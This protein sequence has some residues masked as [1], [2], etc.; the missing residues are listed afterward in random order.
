M[1]RRLVQSRRVSKRTPLIANDRAPDVPPPAGFVTVTF[2]VPAVAISAAGIVA[3]ICVL[4]TDDGVSAGFVPKFTTAP[5]IKPVPV[6]VNVNAAPPRRG[7]RPGR[8][9]LKCRCGNRINRKGLSCR[10]SP[11]RRWIRDSYSRRARCGYIRRRNRRGQL[12]GT[13]E[14]RRLG[15]AIEL[16][17]RPVD[18]NPVP[19]TVNVKAAPPAVA[20]VGEIE[21]SVGKLDY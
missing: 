6:S 16:H 4:V 19:F 13:P 17:N 5:V 3:T 12:G 9:K 7:G 20:L 2:T 21:V 11:T 10:C 1:R 18:T 15:R 14:R 8:S